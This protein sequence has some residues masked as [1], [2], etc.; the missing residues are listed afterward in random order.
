MGQKAQRRNPRSQPYRTPSRLKV[1]VG[2]RRP[3]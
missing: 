1:R 2:N 3:K